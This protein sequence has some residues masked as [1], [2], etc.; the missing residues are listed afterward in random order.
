[1]RKTTIALGALALA[2]ACGHG[3]SADVK[4]FK[5]FK[6][7]LAAIPPC[8]ELKPG[9]LAKASQLT[10]CRD[11]TN[12]LQSAAQYSC[13]NGRTLTAVDDVWS[14]NGGAWTK[15]AAPITDC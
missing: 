9:T 3:N 11:A 14:Y 10:G 6:Q 13:K 1:M 2:T 7:Q 15:G 8:S 12:T 4:E 5:K